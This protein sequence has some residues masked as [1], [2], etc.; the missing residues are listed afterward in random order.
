[1]AYMKFGCSR[2]IVD[3]GYHLGRRYTDFKAEYFDKGGYLGKKLIPKNGALQTVTDMTDPVVMRLD[4]AD[5]LKLPPLT[6][7]PP[8]FVDLP[9][10]ARE[11]YRTLETQTFIAFEDTGTFVDNPHAAALRNRCAQTAGGAIYAEHEANACPGVAADTLGQQAR[12]RGAYRRTP[13]RTPDHLVSIPPRS[14]TAKAPVPT[15]RAYWQRDAANRKP[16]DKA[17][18]PHHRQ[19]EPLAKSKA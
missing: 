17:H 5:W 13:R 16:S 7:P 9:D 18:R 1:M 15:V 11:I 8:I 4:S 10:D 3:R 12:H 2:Q 19:V 14:H 6:T